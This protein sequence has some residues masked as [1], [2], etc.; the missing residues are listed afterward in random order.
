MKAQAKTL[1]NHIEL[2]NGKL[3]EKGPK[4]YMPESRNELYLL[5]KW[6]FQEMLI[7]SSSSNSI[8][9]NDITKYLNQ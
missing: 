6:L 3:L 8:R 4:Q 1:L 2:I 7:R 5:Y 9:S